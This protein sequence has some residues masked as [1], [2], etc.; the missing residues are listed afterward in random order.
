MKNNIFNEI[1]N[2]KKKLISTWVG[3]NNPFKT[4]TSKHSKK[5]FLG[6]FNIN[7]LKN[8]FESV[9]EL[10]KDTFD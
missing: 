10:I 4:M 6:H 5:F 8:K 7:S 1:S 2:F 3:K 9:N